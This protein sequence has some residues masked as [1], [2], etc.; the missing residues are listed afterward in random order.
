MEVFDNRHIAEYP[1]GK[2]V[3]VRPLPD[4][5]YDGLFYRFALIDGPPAT[6]YEGPFTLAQI[7]IQ[8]CMVR[9]R[10]QLQRL[11]KNGG[12]KAWQWNASYTDFEKA[13]PCYEAEF[14]VRKGQ[15]VLEIIVEAPSKP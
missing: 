5:V 3:A 6:A 11:V 2:L 8:T 4:F 7:I 9:S 15:R 12:I 1:Q 13:L 10:T 14:E